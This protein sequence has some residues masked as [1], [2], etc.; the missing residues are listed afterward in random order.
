MMQMLQALLSA[1]GGGG[2]GNKGGNGG[3]KGGGKAAVDPKKA[4]LQKSAEKL[5]TFPNEQRV[6]IG[7]LNK[8][9]T[10]KQLE[11]H[12]VETIGIKPKLTE[13]TGSSGYA[14][15]A[16]EDDATTAIAGLAGSS[17]AGCDI[18]ADVW[19]GKSKED[20]GEKK[21]KNK[22]SNKPNQQA[23]KQAAAS[24]PDAL[25]KAKV[26]AVDAECKVWVGGMKETTKEGQIK[27][28]FNSN[29]CKAQLVKT[30]KPGT[31]CVTF[32]TS[33][34]ATNAIATM[35]GTTLA[36]E[37]IEVDVWTKVDPAERAAQR[38]ARQ[39]AKK[40]KKGQ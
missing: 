12:I 21:K 34:E 19:T 18:E 4:Q 2:K 30:M 15:F 40:A 17:V 1:K 8:T 37:I 22:G 29:G 9:V 20:G 7:G 36:G 11:K 3:N 32:K 26:A 24:T 39:A 16:S 6:W 13:V 38:E 23:K 35:S 14:A 27:G 28:H 5:K 31:A 10:W 25:L 33:E